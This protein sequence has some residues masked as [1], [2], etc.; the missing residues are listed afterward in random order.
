LKV[1]E[2]R[3]CSAE[4]KPAALRFPP[5]VVGR[6]TVIHGQGLFKSPIR[7]RCQRYALG[8]RVI[9]VH[10]QVLAIAYLVHAD[11]ADQLL[12]QRFVK[13]SFEYEYSTEK[14]FGE[15]NTKGY[16]GRYRRYLSKVSFVTVRISSNFHQGETLL[17]SFNVRNN[18]T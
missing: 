4:A 12:I 1:L 16:E 5:N 18:L 10:V 13:A 11:L 6:K 15:L 2:S 8:C 14:G 17:T 7:D 9:H 3:A